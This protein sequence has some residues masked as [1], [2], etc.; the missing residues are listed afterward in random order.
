LGAPYFV[1]VAEQL[2]NNPL[3]HG[4]ATEAGPDNSK[5]LAKA[6]VRWLCRSKCFETAL[7]DP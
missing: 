2:F 5:H 1:R 7:A 4:S 6:R 3:F